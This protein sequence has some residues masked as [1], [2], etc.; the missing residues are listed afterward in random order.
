MVFG[1][2]TAKDNIRD[3][4]RENRLFVWRE[5]FAN[6]VVTDQAFGTWNKESKALLDLCVKSSFYLKLDA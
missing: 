1:D 2:E 3:F 4:Y 5:D 6:M